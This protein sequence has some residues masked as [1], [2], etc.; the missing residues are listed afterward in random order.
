MQERNIDRM[1]LARAPT[2]N[3]GMRPDGESNQRPL[4]LQAG[5]QSNET[6]QPIIFKYLD[7]Y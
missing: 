3:P 4:A 7:S 1:P 2:G 5:T 6:H